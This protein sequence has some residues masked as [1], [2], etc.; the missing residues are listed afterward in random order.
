MMFREWRRIL[1]EFFILKTGWNLPRGSRLRNIFSYF[2]SLEIIDLFLNRS[3][4]FNKP[5]YNLLD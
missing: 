1:L 2:I 3:P 5:T 4:M